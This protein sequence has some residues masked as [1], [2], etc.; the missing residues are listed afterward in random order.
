[1]AYFVDVKHDTGIAY[2]DG[3]AQGDAECGSVM[4]I[5]G[6]DLFAVADDPAEPAFGILFKDVADGD[7]PTIYTQGGVY[8]TDN[9]TGPI[10]ADDLLKVHPDNH[11]LTAGLAEGERAVAQAISADGGVLKFRL[12]V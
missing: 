9:F 11:N 6:N 3:Y 7:M 5:V 12:L 10:T 2:G 4:K 1:M 8:E